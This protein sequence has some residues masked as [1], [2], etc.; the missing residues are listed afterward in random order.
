M[1]LG[2]ERKRM[3]RLAIEKILGYGEPGAEEQLKNGWV[4][5][6]GPWIVTGT[7]DVNEAV[8]FVREVQQAQVLCVGQ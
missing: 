1:V 3:K 2:E 4:S 6:Y 5:M 8:E 7:E